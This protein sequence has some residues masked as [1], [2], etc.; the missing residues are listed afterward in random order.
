MTSTVAEPDA[1]ATN[2]E[3]A[4]KSPAK[5]DEAMPRMLAERKLE[6]ALMALGVTFAECAGLVVYDPEAETAY[7]KYDKV[8]GAE[9]IHVGP[10]VCALDGD[11]IELVLRHEILHRS[12]YNGFGERFTR[13]DLS[14]LVLDV[15]I[16]RLLYEA[17]PDGMRKLS[18][19]IYPAESK[20][21]LIALA[22]CT[23]SP[24][25]SPTEPDLPSLWRSIW[26]PQ[27]D[28][29]LPQL[30]PASLYFRLLRLHEHDTCLCACA[31]GGHA[32]GTP[33][34]LPGKVARAAGAVVSGINGRL[35]RGSDLGSALN[36]YAVLP[37]PIGTDRVE[38]FLKKLRVRR[39]ADRV[40]TRVLAPYQ[41]E[42]R[43]QPYP[44][45]PSRVGL[46]YQLCGVTDLFGL[47]WNREVSNAGA[48]LA[49]GVYV[50]VSGSM[51]PRFP[52]VASIVDALKEFPI[53]LRAFDTSVR[54][55]ELEA[56][57]RGSITGGGGTDFDAPI[58]DFLDAREAEAAVL[59][60]DGEAPVSE[61]VGRRLTTSRKKLYA[62]Y[63]LDANA[64]PMAS[65]LDRYATD[66]ITVTFEP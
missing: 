11:S 62:V 30:N 7:W 26:S 38:D 32:E 48:R 34:N 27:P 8:T 54:E 24:T 35:P 50:D 4:T 31:L 49:I 39:V 21:T 36:E 46:V 14:N 5:S 63:L 61:A 25:V 41:R 9:S 28:G 64:P 65:A 3:G 16:N 17:F 45:F 13:P 18:S 20:T 2:T 42:V 40:A 58:R 44:A 57:T 66:T 12:I 23:A 1:D 29:R 56:F 19:A 10:T 60:T 51:V 47:Y 52:V 43:V 15:C 33:N 37:V 22:D 6:Q 59:I 53:R 55:V